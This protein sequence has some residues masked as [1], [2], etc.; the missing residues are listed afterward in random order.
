MSDPTV[1][2]FDGESGNEFRR[3]QGEWEWW[4]VGRWCSLGHEWH[5]LDP[6]CRIDADTIEWLNSQ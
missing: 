6:A 4:H 2:V 5:R 3:T 1:F